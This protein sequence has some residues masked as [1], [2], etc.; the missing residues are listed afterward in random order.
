MNAE[1]GYFC[2]WSY[3]LYNCWSFHFRRKIYGR[4]VFK[5]ITPGDYGLWVRFVLVNLLVFTGC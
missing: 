1:K 4:R 5:W 3:C 2:S